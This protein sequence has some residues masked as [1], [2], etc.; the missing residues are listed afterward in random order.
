LNK[1]LDIHQQEE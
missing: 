1:D